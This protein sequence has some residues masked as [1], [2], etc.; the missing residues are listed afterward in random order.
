MTNIPDKYVCLISP[1]KAI[2]IW[3]QIKFISQYAKKKHKKTTTW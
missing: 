2:I 1:H 3:F